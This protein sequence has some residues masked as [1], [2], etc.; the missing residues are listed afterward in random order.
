MEDASENSQEKI[1]KLKLLLKNAAAVIKDK[2]RQIA[3][4]DRR[5]STVDCAI[6]TADGGMQ[7]ESK[8]AE[9]HKLIGLFKESKDK[10]VRDGDDDGDE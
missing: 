1:A 5:T 10:L 4:L 6:Q 7:L 9:Q 8:L 2:E 3:E